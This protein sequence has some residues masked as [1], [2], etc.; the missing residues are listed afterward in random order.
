MELVM[1]DDVEALESRN[2]GPDTVFHAAPGTLHRMVAIT[3]CLLLEVS[4]HQLD[5]VVR[6]EDRYGRRG[7]N[8]P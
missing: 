4:T 6:L 5:D 3:D 1:G 2:V 8:V 7:T